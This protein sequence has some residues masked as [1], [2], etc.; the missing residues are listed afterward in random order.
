MVFAPQGEVLGIHDWMAGSSS[1]EAVQVLPRW[2]SWH[3]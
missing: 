2:H 1:K 3:W